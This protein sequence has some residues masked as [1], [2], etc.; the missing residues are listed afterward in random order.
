MVE[1]GAQLRLTP[2]KETYGDPSQLLVRE[3]S[4]SSAV[5]VISSWTVEDT[6]KPRLA[7]EYF[8]DKASKVS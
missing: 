3:G 5:E 1:D 2:P 8:R 6:F 4:C 7:Y